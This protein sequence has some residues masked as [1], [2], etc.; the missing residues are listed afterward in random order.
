MGYLILDRLCALGVAGFI[1]YLSYRLY[2]SA[3]PVLVDEYALD[4]EAINDAVL[5]ISG[6][7]EVGRIR[8]RWI[9]SD[10][11]IDMVVSVNAELTPYK[12]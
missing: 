7:K 2:K 4:P 5:N 9:G 11:T 8:S 6:V 3:F 12:T 1:F 10:I